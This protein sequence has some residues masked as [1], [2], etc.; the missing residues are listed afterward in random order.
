MN[1]AVKWL[2]AGLMGSLLLNFFLIFIL[3][4]VFG[5]SG[6]MGMGF[7]HR[8]HGAGFS[9]GGMTRHLSPEARDIVHDTIGSRREQMHQAMSTIR[10]ARREVGAVLSA[11]VYDAQALDTAFT[12]VRAAHLEMQEAIHG[13]IIE[14]AGK[15]PDGERRDLAKAGERFMRRMERH[16]MPGMQKQH[17]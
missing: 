7:H 13:A 6:G 8:P 15:L 12:G 17:P 11:D 9:L 10:G 4:R 5:E 1:G 2:G 14:A 3:V 16:H